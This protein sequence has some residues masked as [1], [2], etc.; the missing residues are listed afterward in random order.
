MGVELW[1]LRNKQWRQF[2]HKISKKLNKR[3]QDLVMVRSEDYRLQM[4]QY[5]L[6]QKATPLHE[7]H[8]SSYWLMSLRNEGTRYVPVGNI[9]SGLWCPVKENSDPSGLQIRRPGPQKGPMLVHDPDTGEVRGMKT[10][11]D[12][13]LLK[14][15]AHELRK[16]VKKIRA[17]DINHDVAEGL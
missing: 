2:E 4:E 16:Y 9:F 10:W 8:G 5:D 17:P 3:E 13:H 1:N 15:R 7:K 12:S 14:A 6:L 11:E